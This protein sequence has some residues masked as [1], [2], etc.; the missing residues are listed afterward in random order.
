VEV[1]EPGRVGR[2]VVPGVSPAGGVGEF[3]YLGGSGAKEFID[4]TIPAGETALT[5]QIQAVR[6]TAVGLWATFNV[7]FGTNSAGGATTSVTETSAPKIA[8]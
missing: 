2:D 8:A 3:E 7:N 5:Y 1:R 6:S 4:A